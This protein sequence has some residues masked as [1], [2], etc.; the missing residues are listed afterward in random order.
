M[1]FVFYKVC[2][3]TFFDKTLVLVVFVK[4]LSNFILICDDILIS[5]DSFFWDFIHIS[6]ILFFPILTH[7]FLCFLSNAFFPRRWLNP[8]FNFWFYFSHKFIFE[9]AYS[10]KVRYYLLQISFS[11]EYIYWRCQVTSQSKDRSSD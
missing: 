9:A 1:W 2:F 3:A 4:C 7:L 6:L 5:F 11:K 10:W 8:I